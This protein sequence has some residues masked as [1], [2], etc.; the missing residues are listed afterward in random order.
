MADA[1]KDFN[2]DH[3]NFFIHQ[4]DD[5]NIK[6]DISFAD[7]TVWMTQQQ[8]AELF[9]SSRTNIA[10]HIQHIY[11]EGEQEERFT[12]RKFRQVR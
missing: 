2:D 7:E 5:G 4:G 3:G 11:D 10:E 6:I 9:Q 1:K 12:C 8:I